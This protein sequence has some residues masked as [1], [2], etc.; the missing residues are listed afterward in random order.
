MTPLR[1]DFWIQ[2]PEQNNLCFWPRNFALVNGEH[3]GSCTENEN[4]AKG[5]TMVDLSPFLKLAA[6]PRVSLFSVLIL[7][8]VWVAVVAPLRADDPPTYLFQINSNAVPGGLFA[9]AGV[10][11][12]TS[13]NVYVANGYNRVEKFDSHGNYLTQWGSPGGGNGHDSHQGR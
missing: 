10:A 1:R 6:R 11:L 2:P 8:P 9:P 3:V 4:Y 7:L 12:D 5:T 13:N